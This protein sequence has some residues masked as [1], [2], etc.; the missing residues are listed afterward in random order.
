MGNQNNSLVQKENCANELRDKIVKEF[1]YKN[2]YKYQKLLGKNDFSYMIVAYSI[3][4]G[5]LVSIKVIQMLNGVNRVNK[6]KIDEQMQTLQKIR[7]ESYVLYII[8]SIQDEEHGLFAIVYQYCSCNLDTI[9]NLNKLE[10]EQVLAMAYQLLKGLI[11]LYENSI[12]HNNIK[13][14]NILFS[15][16][17]NLFLITDFGLNQTP[18]SFKSTQIFCCRDSENTQGLVIQYNSNMKNSDIFN[19]GIILIEAFIQRRLTQNEKQDIIN[20]PSLLQA[21]PFLKN[22]K[23]FKFVEQILCKMIDQNNDDTKLLPYSL[24]QSLDQFSINENSLKQLRIQKEKRCIQINE[25]YELQKIVDTEILIINFRKKNIDAKTAKDIRISLEKCKNISDLL[26]DFSFNKLGLIGAL[27]L[28]KSL[29]KCQNIETIQ[30]YLKD[31]YLGATGVKNI[32]L[33]F[34]NCKNLELLDLK[35]SINNLRA[36]GAKNIGM[37]LENCQNIIQLNL[38][39]GYNAICAEGAKYIGMSLEKCQSIAYLKLGLKFNKLGQEGVKS[40][41]KSLEKLKD[42]NLLKLNLCSNRLEDLA[43]KSLG[44][45]IGKWQNIVNLNINLSKNSITDDGVQNLLVNLQN[46]KNIFKLSLNIK[47]TLQT[48]QALEIIGKSLEKLPELISF[49]LIM[50]GFNLETSHSVEITKEDKAFKNFIK[51]L[52]Q[53][54]NLV[55]LDIILNSDYDIMLKFDIG[56]KKIKKLVRYNTFY[57]LNYNEY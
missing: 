36:E 15:K 28:G 39:L 40:I 5:C 54:N 14:N 24:L 46:C 27:H 21:L 16:Y 52:Q 55:F 20:Q 30:L 6:K 22:S 53:C 4:F 38:N 23:K 32:G 10:L 17:N 51:S 50:T 18:Q 37:I 25:L 43:V 29:E 42:I 13:P 45:S 12:T 34:Q 2:N 1:L 11:I 19:L 26:F 57:S 7:N 48:Q 56:L 47:K 3:K 44:I 9:L 41:A 8:E 35:M 49:Q 33:I 31:N